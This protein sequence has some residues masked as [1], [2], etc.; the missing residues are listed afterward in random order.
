MKDNTLQLP[1]NPVLFGTG[2]TP[3]I[4]AIEP[5]ETT[6]RLF[7]RTG[8]EERPL[9][10]FLWIA[11]PGLIEGGTAEP[12]HGEA[13]LRWL[14]RFPSWEALATARK[15][16]MKAH[17]GA[18][19]LFINDAVQQ[20]LMDSGETL[21]GGMRPGDLRRVQVELRYGPE[22]E[23][24]GAGVGEQVLEGDEAALL[25]GLNDAI[26]QLDPD[27]LEGH[28]LG[29]L[30]L[31]ALL[32]R[33]RAAGVQLT[34]GRDGSELAVTRSRVQFAER[35]VD[36]PRWEVYG[37]HVVDTWLLVQLHDI[38]A[39][40]M[41]GYDLAEAGPYFGVTVTEVDIAAALRI[42]RAISDT[43]SIAYFLQAQ[44]LPYTYQN[45]V[46]RGNA[47]KINALFLREYLR[48]REALPP[49][50]PETVAYE[51]GYTDVFADG[52]VR[53]VVHCDVQSLYPSIM[54]AFD[55]KPQ[56]DTLGIFLPLL[57]DLREMRLEA[58]ALASKVGRDADR[59]YY[60]GLQQTF[61]ILINSFYGYLGTSFSNFADTAMA[62]EVTRRGRDIVKSVI[63]GLSKRGCRPIEIDT[64][65]V[66]FVPPEGQD[67]A[68]IVAGL[69]QKLPAGI[70]LEV[71]ASYPAMFS[72]KAKNYALLEAGGKLRIKGSGLK[73][74]GTEK[75]LRDF[76]EDLLR[77][78]LEGRSAEVEALYDST[79]SRLQQRAI[80]VRDLC[81]TETLSETLSAY[82]QKVQ[83]KK[84]NAAAAYELAIQ[85]G[86]KYG[87]GDTVSY[88]VAGEAKK[89][90]VVDCARLAGAYN[91]DENVAW[92]QQ[93]LAELLERF[94][95]WLPPP[96]QARLA[97]PPRKAK[98]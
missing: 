82:Q 92:Y 73:S 81:K 44:M 59:Q 78:L 77:L 70:V 7:S 43:L 97:P 16:M 80:P 87:P 33:A 37:R 4:V 21:F 72:Y 94:L 98:A 62:A 26:A 36:T 31:A 3:G 5:G 15:A 56:S 45:C 32:K 12:L 71:D 95:P 22:G 27:V 51:G 85:S 66:Y 29:R 47:T 54:L 90:R 63:D 14:V 8:V 10:P 2:T 50:P 30:D 84:R 52:V 58:K 75:F 61:K 68:A 93:K 41:E 11:D 1:Q 74:R 60:T 76:T 69:S 91:A 34:W 25:R 23:L 86:A 28:D 40:D 35:V 6:V 55:V 88:Y 9:A 64:D 19:H 20:F 18:L 53:P 79:L 24:V 17:K 89:V 96:L 67:G 57:K 49:E 83:Q 39:R 13:P 38:S 46:V 48:R 42:T 65:G